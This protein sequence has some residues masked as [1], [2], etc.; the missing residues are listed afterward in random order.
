MKKVYI[1]ATFFTM[2]RENNIFE[3]GMMVVQD[4]SISYIGQYSEDKLTDVDQ[5]VDLHGKWVLPG[6]VNAHSHI[7]MTLLRGIG[8]DMLLK[9]WLETKIWPLESQFNTEIASVSAQLGI[10]E[11]VKTGTTTFSDMFNPN[12]IDSDE[13]MQTI[14]KTGIR[15]AFSHTIFSLGTEEEQKLNIMQAERFARNYKTV[16]DD[17]LT[18]MVAPHS[19]YACTPEALLE[20]LR[21]SKENNLMIHIHVSET[22]YEVSNIEKC[23][24]FR[25]I[26]HLRRLGI[27]DQPTVIAHGVLLNDEE[28]EIL[29]QHDVRVAHNPISNLKLGSGIADIVSLLNAG[30]KVGIATDSVA[31]NNNLDMFEEMRTAALLQKGIYK[32]ATKLPAHSTLALATRVG[33]QVIGMAHTGS[34]EIN[35]KADFITIYPYDKEHLQPISEAYSHLLYAARGNDV[36][37]VFIDGKT[38]VKDGTC[39]TIDEEKVIAEANRLQKTL[40]R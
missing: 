22:D 19:P 37:D 23:Y 4:K 14:G 5:V 33:A 28:R 15:G 2:D 32:D 9:P 31:S 24:G 40:S 20:S 30:I 29:K 7:L 12:G 25:P 26:E 10:L 11:M 8:D 16:A 6:L 3:N 36:C 17:R 39:L 34:L 27:F 1:N 13:V 21:I 18:T 35:K 38:I